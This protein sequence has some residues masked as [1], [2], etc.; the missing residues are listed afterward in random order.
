MGR[1]IMESQDFRMRKKV[2]ILFTCPGLDLII[3]QRKLGNL[4]LYRVI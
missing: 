3:K 2:D 1:I 4:C